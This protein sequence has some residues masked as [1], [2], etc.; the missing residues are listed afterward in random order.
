M[1]RK[2]LARRLYLSDSIAKDLELE[3]KKLLRD[4]DL[5]PFVEWICRL[6]IAGQRGEIRATRVKEIRDERDERPRKTG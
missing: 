3:M 1:P 2:E 5:S 4:E 6:W